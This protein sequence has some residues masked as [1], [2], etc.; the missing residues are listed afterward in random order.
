[1]TRLSNELA[2]MA[3]GGRHAAAAAPGN[4]RL[5][6]WEDL[7]GYIVDRGSSLV[8][9]PERT[10]AL[11][12]HLLRRA[13]LDEDA[14]WALDRALRSQVFLGAYAGNSRAVPGLELTAFDVDKLL[15]ERFRREPLTVGAA[16]HHGYWRSYFSHAAITHPAND[17]L[18]EEFSTA[19]DIVR[20]RPAV[21]YREDDGRRAEELHAVRLDL[22]LIVGPL[23]CGQGV[24]LEVAYLEAIAQADPAHDIRSRSLVVIEADAAVAHAAELL[25]HAA[26]LVVRL[27]PRH[28][29]ALEGSAP[30]GGAL[31]E[32][33]RAARLVELDPWGDDRAEAG[34]EF[35]TRLG[36]EFGTRF[37]TEFGTRFGTDGGNTHDTAGA[38]GAEAL[39]ALAGA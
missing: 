2:E 11:L 33:V 5:A 1:M 28:I 19:W 22:P 8:S 16:W 37:G 29:A 17:G 36:T 38:A 32:L 13:G 10:A 20:K 21:L 27:A 18:R 39:G 31:A 3:A 15:K 25:P 24:R 35:G 9:D 14:F 7:L 6:A 4:G 30:D 34:T 12:S 23:P 26:D